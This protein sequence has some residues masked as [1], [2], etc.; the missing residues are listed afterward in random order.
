VCVCVCVG[1]CVCVCVCV[2]VR[3]RARNEYPR[4][5]PTCGIHDVPVRHVREEVWPVK[6]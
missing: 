4:S 5:S 6:L 1:V 3:A 2:C